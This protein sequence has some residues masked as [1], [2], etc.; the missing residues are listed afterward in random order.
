MAQKLDL[1]MGSTHLPPKAATPARGQQPAPAAVPVVAE[2]AKKGNT[3]VLQIRLPPGDAK[4][5]R[6][7]AAERE[8]SISDF[9]LM[10]VREWQAR[11]P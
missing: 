11:N 1:V 4:A 2:N 10:C 9:V 7:T 3:A 6:V 8:Q 5:I